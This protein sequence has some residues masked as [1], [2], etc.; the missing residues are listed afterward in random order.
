[1]QAKVPTSKP[2]IWLRAA[3]PKT[4]AAAVAP[5][6]VGTA[7]AQEAGGLHPWAALAAL[8]GALLI[9][10]GTNFCNDI[11]DFQKGGDTA[12]RKGPLRATQ[13]GLVSPRAMR[14]ATVLAFTLAV[15]VGLYL[16]ARGGWPVAVIG[17]LS[18]AAGVLYSAGRYPLAYIGLG[19]LFVLIFFGPV[20]VAGTYYVQVLEVNATVLVAG[21]AT[22]LLATAILQVNNIRD[23]EEDR[24]AGKRTLVVRFGRRFGLV[25]WA[26]CVTVAALIP[27][28]LLVATAQHRW[29]AL[30]VLILIPGLAVFHRLR[31]EKRLERLSPLLG[32]TG[33]LLLAHSL[34]FGLGWMLS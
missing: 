8:A 2:L 19:D 25:L 14:L 20:A 17:V 27:L 16:I 7:M 34:L 28:E 32:W 4:L 10:I 5:V 13:S 29:A 23:R 30:T 33:L 22:G 15:A 9:Q 11:A 18:I 12:A 31:T 26:L 6:M 21:L 24:K 3:R 1:M